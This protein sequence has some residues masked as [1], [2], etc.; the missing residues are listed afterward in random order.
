MLQRYKEHCKTIQR[1]EAE[2]MGTSD[3]R[4]R[5]DSLET[6]ATAHYSLQLLQE[7]KYE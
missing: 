1:E 4:Y 7:K 6:K 3:W 5:G 2:P